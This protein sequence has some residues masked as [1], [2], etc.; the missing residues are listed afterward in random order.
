MKEKSTWPETLQLATEL[1]RISRFKGW[2]ERSRG[3][4]CGALCM[5]GA[6][7]CWI[8]CA[9]APQ[10]LMRASPWT[11]LGLEAFAP[12]LSLASAAQH[13]LALSQKPAA[14][15]DELAG[16]A[17]AVQLG[18]A[19][20]V[21]SSL[22]PN[23]RSPTA[24]LPLVGIHGY[25]VCLCFICCSVCSLFYHL[26][27]VVNVQL[28]L[29]CFRAIHEAI[30]APPSALASVELLANGFNSVDARRQY[31]PMSCSS[32]YC[33]GTALLVSG[34]LIVLTDTFHSQVRINKTTKPRRNS[35]ADIAGV[36]SS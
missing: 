21:S 32:W 22:Q 18:F 19:Y 1:M 26:R 24:R 2:W 8:G 5:L 34:L 36:T 29:R 27:V 14:L 33:V 6:I 35:G 12:C 7:S 30:S 15:S 3:H 20:M 4:I 10:S 17:L 28:H 11:T 23:T 25:S 9:I 13:H 31:R 16:V